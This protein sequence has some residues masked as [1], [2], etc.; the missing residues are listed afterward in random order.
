MEHRDVPEDEVRK[1]E[2]VRTTVNNKRRQIIL[3]SLEGRY[4]S[5]EILSTVW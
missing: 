1:L 3:T 2:E 5:E 4:P